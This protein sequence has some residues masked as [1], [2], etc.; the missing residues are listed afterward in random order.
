MP[1][2]INL[3]ELF[4]LHFINDCDEVHDAK[5]EILAFV[6]DVCQKTLEL[7]AENAKIK[8]FEARWRAI[9]GVDK[10]SILD[11]IKQIK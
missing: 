1:K 2:E 11:T 5:I 6:K 9:N 3:E 8:D 4:D 10:Q 7:A